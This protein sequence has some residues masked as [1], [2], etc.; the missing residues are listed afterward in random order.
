[1]V[2]MRL[3]RTIF[4]P[5][6]PRTGTLTPVLLA[7]YMLCAPFYIMVG[8]MVIEALLAATTTYLVIQ[9]GKDVVNDQFILYD[10]LGILAAQS[11]S[12]V[13]GAISWIYAERAGFLAYARY[14]MRFAR[15]NRDQT[16]S[17]FDKDS[18]ERVEP[19]LTGETFYVYFN[20][21]YEIE[22]DLRLILGLL[23]NVIVI[24]SEIDGSLP[25]AYAAA[26]G[27]LF[28]MQWTMRKPI[29]R[30][31]L[32][33]QRMTNRMT[34]QGYTAWDNIYTGNRYNLRLW[35]NGFKSKLRD[36]VDAQIKA[37]MTKESLSAASAIIGL[38]IIF[39]TM[40]W[41]ASKNVQNPEILIAL[42][43]TLPRQIDMTHSMHEFTQGWNELLAVW[44]RLR[45]V[46]SNFR[47][48]VDPQFDAR[49]KPDRLV[50]RENDTS[51][52]INSIDEAF[53]MIAASRTG[54][55][56]V[57]GSNGSG[58]ST[59]LAS[60][61]SSLKTR[62][63]YWP[64]ADRLSF[65]FS[66]G[67]EPQDTEHGDEE[68]GDESET[69]KSEKRPGFSSGER[70]LRAL[71]EIVSYT[72]AEIYLLDEWDANLDPNNRAAADAL[73]EELARRARVV[74]ISHRDRM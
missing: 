40:A 74:E 71:Q 61:K 37:I 73:V 7:R 50:L 41:V 34:A 65:E 16:K 13:V 4:K 22:Q 47:P 23:F 70:Q 72:A 24:G 30:A 62:A 18:R 3:L 66:R 29:A 44:T 1:M 15:D 39:G 9:A 59:L 11:L 55:I 58:K 46:A 49:I 25:V 53:E 45:G 19:F 63:Y 60:L 6:V 33:N 67:M 36:G 5:Q 8:L 43:A 20:L 42:A 52:T 57:R 2:G 27:V 64:T 26:F 38:G 56:N 10:L 12:Y 51:R 17:L 35:L 21:I 69:K 48:P 54:R 31:Y 68:G 32:E 28:L 14:M